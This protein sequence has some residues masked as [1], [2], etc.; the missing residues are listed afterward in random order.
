M[1]WST[2]T[3]T[4]LP[5]PTAGTAD[6][7][8]MQPPACAGG[9]PFLV[10][11]SRRWVAA[12]SLHCHQRH[13][14][15]RLT[16]AG[17]VAN[18]PGRTRKPLHQWLLIIAVAAGLIGMHNLVVP[19]TSAHDPRPHTAGT[20]PTHVDMA[21]ALVGTTT[22]GAVPVGTGASLLGSVDRVVDARAA[23]S[24][25]ADP[26]SVSTSGCCSCMGAMMGH[27]CQAVLG[28]DAQLEAAAILLAATTAS[29]DAPQA[30]AVGLASPLP[31]RS[32]PSSG[33]RFSQLGVWR[34]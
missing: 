7:E 16:G 22:P 27:P 25:A 30:M 23:T 1:L 8:E 17:T 4:E 19:A 28:A 13:R 5:L 29:H 31:A 18:V 9:R 26:V 10:P 6:P 34:R 32:P 15:G 12:P 2:A 14:I 11:T 21:G 24:E 20:A 33:V 3:T